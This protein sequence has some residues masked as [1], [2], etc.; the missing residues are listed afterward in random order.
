MKISKL[1][2]DG[3]GRFDGGFE[4]ESRLKRWHG[5]RKL[6]PI[7]DER[8]LQRANYDEPGP[9]FQRVNRRVSEMLASPHDIHDLPEIIQLLRGKDITELV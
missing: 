4:M 9:A 2:L 1:S 8:A 5:G 6:C 7:C 3:F